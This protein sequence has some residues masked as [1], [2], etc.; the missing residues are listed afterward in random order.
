[1][2]QHFS[3]HPQFGQPSALLPLPLGKHVYLSY[4]FVSGPNDQILLIIIAFADPAEPQLACA[5]AVNPNF[6]TWEKAKFLDGYPQ[7][8]DST[9]TWVKIYVPV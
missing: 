1:M 7:Y 9:E 4:H 2:N 8:V 3:S 5:Y 6:V